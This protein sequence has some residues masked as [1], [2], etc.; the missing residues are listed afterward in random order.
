M[1]VRALAQ[2]IEVLCFHLPT[3]NGRPVRRKRLAP[4]TGILLTTSRATAGIETM[5]RG[6]SLTVTL[7]YLTA[8]AHPTGPARQP[9]NVEV[10]AARESRVNQ[11][12]QN[13]AAAQ[14]F[15]VTEPDAR[16]VRRAV[17][18]I[19]VT[20]QARLVP[21]FIPVARS[22]GDQT[23]GLP[24]CGADQ[25]DQIAAVA[26][27]SNRS[28]YG[29]L[30]VPLLVVCAVDVTLGAALTAAANVANNR[31]VARKPKRLVRGARVGAQTAGGLIVSGGSA[32]YLAALSP[33]LGGLGGGLIGAMCVGAGTAV[34]YWLVPP[35]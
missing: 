9:S 15:L 1:N 3:V 31:L 13:V 28:L 14:A 10:Q 33:S 19:D 26:D 24:A 35:Q 2:R 34:G 30:I 27:R 5:R 22:G 6:L 7:A 11:V 8:C 21:S 25:L 17:C 16:G 12:F 20:A 23:F 29:G 18:R 4:G 32:G